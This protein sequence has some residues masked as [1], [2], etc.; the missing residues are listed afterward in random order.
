MHV[1]RLCCR[2][3]HFTY[4]LPVQSRHVN[5]MKHKTSISCYCC[6]SIL[7]VCLFLFFILFWYLNCLICFQFYLFISFIYFFFA[8][9]FSGNARPFPFITTDKNLRSA[10]MLYANIF[11]APE[12]I[13]Q[14]HYC[15]HALSVVR[16]SSLTF[17]ILDFSS[18]PT[19]RN[20]TEHDR[21]KDLIVLYQAFGFFPGLIRKTRWPPWPIRQKG[22]TLYS[23]AR[24]MALW[25]PCF[26]LDLFIMFHIVRR[27]IAYIM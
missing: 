21:K 12:T 11:S 9:Q 25:S 17:H 16:P 4:Y 18:E 23:G 10:P 24:Y 27:V 8:S 26:I 5:A 6:L 13:A 14:V 1:F 15:D 2:R 22:G 19:E 3:G 20:S 7:F